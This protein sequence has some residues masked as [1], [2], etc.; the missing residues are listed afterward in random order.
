MKSTLINYTQA[1]SIPFWNNLGNFNLQNLQ[2]D[3]LKTILKETQTPIYTRLVKTNLNKIKIY[4]N[5][6]F[7]LF[8][9]QLT[10]APYSKR[11]IKSGHFIWL[12]K[13]E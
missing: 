7:R 8:G 13:F 3:D 12:Q 4:L 6:F 1:R 10:K 11:Q 9:Y 5:D 2:R